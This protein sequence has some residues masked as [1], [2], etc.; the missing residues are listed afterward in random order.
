[1]GQERVDPTL[2]ER[3]LYRLFHERG[4]KVFEPQ[5]VRDS[6]RCSSEGITNMLKGFSPQERRDM[7]GDNGKIGVTCE[8]CS[9]F[10][11]FDPTDFD[12]G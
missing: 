7:I 6:C 2:C 1:M 8:F 4:V 9:T 10:R 5:G 3:L 12:E 11:E